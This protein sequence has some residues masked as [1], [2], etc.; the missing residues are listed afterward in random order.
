V[1]RVAQQT[2]KE[3]QLVSDQVT[4][5]EQNKIK[6]GLDVS[7][8]NVNLAQAQL[9]LVR[10]QN[11]VEASYAQLSEALGSSTEQTFDL[12][13]MPVPPEPPTNFADL[14]QEA[15]RDRPERGARPL[16]SDD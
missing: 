11:D 12:A 2:V 16:V 7:F 3:R 13:D 9:L 10:A 6:S 5:L 4:T 15:M 14:L 1:L 8:A